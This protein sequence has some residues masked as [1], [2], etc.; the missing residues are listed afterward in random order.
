M[1]VVALVGVVVN[2]AAAWVLARRQPQEPQHRGLVP[3]HAD[4]PLRLH[5]HRRSPVRDRALDGLGSAPMRSPRCFVAGLMLRAAYGLLRDSG[6]IFL[7][8]S[9]ERISTPTRSAARSSPSPASS[10]STTSTSGRSRRASPP[11]PR[12]CS[13]RATATATPTRRRLA[14]VLTSSFGIGHTT[15]QVDHVAAAAGVADRQRESRRASARSDADRMPDGL[16]LPRRRVRRA[17]PGSALQSSSHGMK[18]RLT[19]SAAA[20]CSSARSSAATPVR[21]IAL[22]SR[23]LASQGASSAVKPVGRWRPRREG[24]RSRAPRRAR[25]PAAGGAPR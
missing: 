23:V 6:R 14:V 17:R 7:E 19:L 22:T 11:C 20:R 2:L 8:A 3:A 10:R 21:S 16:R 9:P 12:T 1:L 15:L 25:R 24:P 5:R 4:R 13:S 18:T